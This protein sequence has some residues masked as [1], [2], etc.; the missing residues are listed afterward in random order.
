M[1]FVTFLVFMAVQP[2]PQSPD[3]WKWLHFFLW[4][5][6]EVPS[7]RQQSTTLAELKNEIRSVIGG[8]DLSTS[9]RKVKQKIGDL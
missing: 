1:H 9:Y 2:S 8:V 7:L 3:C 5:L 6:C 4:G